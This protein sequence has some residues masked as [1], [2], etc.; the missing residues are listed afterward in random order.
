MLRGVDEVVSPDEKD[1]NE[2]LAGWE[3]C[4][5]PAKNVRSY[6]REVMMTKE[7]V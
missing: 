3:E 2:T 5:V 7:K 6:V 4:R 1:E